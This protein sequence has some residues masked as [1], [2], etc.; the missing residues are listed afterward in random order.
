MLAIVRR[1]QRHLQNPDS[2]HRR[3]A[4]GF[5]WVSLF[6]F[7]GKLAGA[8]KEM[9]V[10][11]RYGVSPTVDAYVFVF[12]LVSWPVAVWFGIISAVLVPLAARIRH[13]EPLWV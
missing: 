6:V 3:I 8:A 2:P 12:N 11:W 10:A 1:V 7:V 4:V 5:L 13:A 9:T